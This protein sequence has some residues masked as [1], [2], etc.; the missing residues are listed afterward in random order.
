MSDIK[1]SWKPTGKVVGGKEQY[2]EIIENKCSCPQAKVTVRCGVIDTVEPVDKTKISHIGN[3]EF[4]I[5]AG[6]KPIIKGSPVTFT[7]SFGT[8]QDFPVVSAEPQC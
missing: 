6:G 4:C 3:T 5:I 2:L 1:T 8:P 7:Y